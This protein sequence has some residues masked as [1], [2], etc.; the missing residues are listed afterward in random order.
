MTTRT[1]LTDDQRRGL[2]NETMGLRRFV[3]AKALDESI[4]GKDLA[5]LSRQFLLATDKLLTLFPPPSLYGTLK[6]ELRKLQKRVDTVMRTTTHTRD[7]A[8]L[9]RQYSLIVEAILRVEQARPVTRKSSP[10]EEAQAALKELL[11]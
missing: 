9:A 6:R 3:L 5:A 4:G 7:V 2:Y 8:S 11:G 1:G 10:M